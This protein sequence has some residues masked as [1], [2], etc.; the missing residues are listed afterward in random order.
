MSRF[1]RLTYVLMG[2]SSS[3]AS[4][5]PTVPSKTSSTSSSIAT[6]P[7]IAI[8]IGYTGELEAVVESIAIVVGEVS[9]GVAVRQTLGNTYDAQ[10]PVLICKRDKEV[11]FQPLTY[12]DIS[13]VSHML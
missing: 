4:K 6:N 12:D 7:S 2:Q 13:A 9:V 8:T 10:T 3:I 11:K 1:V 5:T